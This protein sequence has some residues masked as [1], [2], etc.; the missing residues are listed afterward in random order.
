MG[1]LLSLPEVL[2]SGGGTPTYG[3]HNV[4]SIPATTTLE[5]PETHLRVSL[6][7]DPAEAPAE[8]PR[9]RVTLTCMDV[10]GRK[11]ASIH[12]LVWGANRRT[13]WCFV[14]HLGNIPEDIADLHSRYP[15]PPQSDTTSEE[16]GGHS[17]SV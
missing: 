9:V 8:A 11:H 10:F 2:A 17:D 15:S 7:P 13:T 4:T 16:S 12:D 6:A 1:G 14:A 3:M 5:D